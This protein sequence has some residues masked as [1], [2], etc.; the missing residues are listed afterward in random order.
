MIIN[1]KIIIKY[2]L[3]KAILTA[4]ESPRWTPVRTQR[5]KPKT[6]RNSALQN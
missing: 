3:I 6:Q 4:I 2:T 1:N 5:T